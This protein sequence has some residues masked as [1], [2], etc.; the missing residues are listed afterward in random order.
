[1]GLTV[2]A[3]VVGGGGVVDVVVTVVVGKGGGVGQ[4]VRT[5]GGPQSM[6][7]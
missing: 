5:L 3:V 1:M 7:H 2:T 4:G 6:A